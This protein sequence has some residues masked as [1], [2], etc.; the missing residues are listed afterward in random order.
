[1]GSYSVHQVFDGPASLLFSCQCWHVGREVMVMAPPPACDSAESPCF[2]GCLAFLHQ[3]FLPWFPPSAAAAKSLQS[4]LT[5]CGPV[6][7]SSLGSS[8]PGILQAIQEWVAISFSNEWKWKVKVKSLSRVWHSATPWTAAYQAPPSMGF[9]R[10]EYWS[11][12]PLPSLYTSLR[13]HKYII[14]QFC[15]T[16]IWN[17]SH[18]AKIEVSANYIPIP[19]PP[20]RIYFFFDGLLA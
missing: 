13:Q 17:K 20:G 14:L 15:K 7:S 3:H 1:M 5:L 12:V 11:G 18:Q 16:E 4:C 8:V 6:D 19:K 9:S 10:R 2:H